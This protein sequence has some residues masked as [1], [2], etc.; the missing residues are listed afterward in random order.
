MRWRP[1]D[2]ST[3]GLAAPPRPGSG[4][5]LERHLDE[6]ADAPA[7]G[8]G[9][10]RQGV[11]QPGPIDRVDHVAYRATERAL[12]VCSCPTKCQVSPRSAHSATFAAASWSRFSPMSRTPSSASRRMS[13]AGNVLVTTTTVTSAAIATG[14]RTCAP[15]PIVD[16]SQASGNLSL[17]AHG[18]GPVA[19]QPDQPGEA[20]CGVVASIGVQRGV[21][22]RAAG[23]ACRL[24]RRSGAAAQ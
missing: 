22:G 11:D 6:A 21:L 24:R 14:R 5:S 4:S 16:G 18:P 12:F 20:P 1:R 10:P 15:D 2:S 23:R 9:R 13:L 8:G 17:P 3:S 7:V 19:G